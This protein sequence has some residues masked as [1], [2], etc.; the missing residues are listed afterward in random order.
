MISSTWVD[1][2][3]HIKQDAT[4][5]KRKD[6]GHQQ[7]VTDMVFIGPDTDTV[8][9]KSGKVIISVHTQLFSDSLYIFYL[10]YFFFTEYRARDLCRVRE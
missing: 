7:D 6:A 4:K 10:I 9:S 5:V 1:P 8:S 3:H 2:C